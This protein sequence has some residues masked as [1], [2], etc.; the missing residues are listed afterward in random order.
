MAPTRSKQRENNA[1]SR[2]AGGIPVAVRQRRGIG[3]LV[4]NC[5]VNRDRVVHRIFM[6]T[7]GVDVSWF[8]CQPGTTCGT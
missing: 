1:Q 7:E 5:P 8:I 4:F 2:A 3:E 6:A